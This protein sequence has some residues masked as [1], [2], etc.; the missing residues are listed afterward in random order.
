MRLTKTY[1][2]ELESGK[3]DT[4]PGMAYFV[5]TGPKDCQCR[6]CIYFGY[7][8]YYAASNKRYANRLMPAHCRKYT[9]LVMKPGPKI[10]S[11]LL[12]CKYYEK[13]EDPPPE[14]NPQQ[15]LSWGS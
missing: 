6:T 13:S 15:T 2:D 9:S 4:P 14:Y 7:E 3:R 1:S 10:R 8:G 5:G 12:S 11:S